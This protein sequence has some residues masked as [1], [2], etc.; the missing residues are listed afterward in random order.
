MNAAVEFHDSEVAVVEAI[1]GAMYVRFSAAYVHRSKGEPGRDAGAGYVQAVALRL[2]QAVWSGELQACVGT[3]WS[4][5]LSVR[6]E[7]LGLVPLP[8]S[9]EG[10][11]RLRLVFAN[12][13]ELVVEAA[14]VSLS[15]TGEARFVENFTC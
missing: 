5:E 9:A 1:E 4:G 14:S 10:H 8:Y 6:E 3:L 15:Q 12:G 7:N 11:V 2:G 13:A